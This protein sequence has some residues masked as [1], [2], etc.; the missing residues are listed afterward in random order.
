MLEAIKTISRF[1]NSD[2]KRTCFFPVFTSTGRTEKPRK[3][4]YYRGNCKYWR[5]DRKV[6]ISQKCIARKEVLIIAL[7]EKRYF[8]TRV[9]SSILF[10]IPTEIE[11]N[12]FILRKK[13]IAFR[14]IF[15][16]Y[17]YQAAIIVCR[18][19]C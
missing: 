10:S 16:K 14:V 3:Y 2:Y 11:V 17:L 19:S 6:I 4:L 1:L 7:T 5:V 15:S 18:A 13:Q 12:R 9:S 8:F